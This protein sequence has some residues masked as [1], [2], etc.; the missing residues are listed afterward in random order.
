MKPDNTKQHMIKK[1]L[2]NLAPCIGN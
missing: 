2:L 1:V